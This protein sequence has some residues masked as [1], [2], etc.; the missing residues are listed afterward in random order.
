MAS[1]HAGSWRFRLARGYQIK[2][3]CELVDHL[4][5]YGWRKSDFAGYAIGMS[6][7]SVLT[8]CGIVFSVSESDGKAVRVKCY[9][10]DLTGIKMWCRA[11]ADYF[12][13]LVPWLF[14]F[15]VPPQNE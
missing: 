1:V 13:R 14:H 5:R 3:L 2:N 12:Q 7:F 11:V 15:P 9:A 8:T 10:D 4:G 6:G